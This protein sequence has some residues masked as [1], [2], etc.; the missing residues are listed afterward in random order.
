MIIPSEKPSSGVPQIVI[1]GTGYGECILVH[2]G[3]D[4]YVM[5]DSFLNPETKKPI[6]ADY[7][8]NI[9]LSIHNIIGIICTHWDDDHIKGMYDIASNLKGITVGIPV[10]VSKR[11][12]DK[13]R[14][15]LKFAKG[16]QDY[17]PM[18]EFSKLLELN[19][20]KFLKFSYCVPQRQ[21]FRKQIID[22][23]LS[24]VIVETLSPSDEQYTEFIN[25][26]VMPKEGDLMQSIDFTNN[27]ISVVSIVKL[28]STY[29]LF[30]GDLEN[31]HGEWDKVIENYQYPKADIFKIPHHGSKTGY[32]ENVWK[33]IVDKPISIITRFNR[34][35]VS[36]PDNEQVEFIN[37][38]SK[39]MFII[40]GTNKP[41]KGA[42]MR[43]LE[44]LAY[45]KKHQ[46]V[47]R[48]EKLGIV[49]L[50]YSV[51]EWTYEIFGE[52]EEK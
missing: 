10:T 16:S 15:Y 45:S 3:N 50:T 1:M 51:S 27:R 9:G 33:N 26:L 47:R 25:Q 7:L 34:G 38:N 49:R 41:V 19:S 43:V 12:L 40:G 44:G 22:E 13:L 6:A 4:K 20:K 32:S 39:K 37:G 8:D 29:C 18:D 52:V 30:G 24:E 48:K 5:I 2:L 23:K 28:Y 46:M 31:D 17:V 36:L 21:L 42:E 35:N 14:E 11:D